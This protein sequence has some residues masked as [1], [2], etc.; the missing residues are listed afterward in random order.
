MTNEE[1]LIDYLKW[2]TADLHKTRQRLR[3]VE[4]AGQEPIAIVGMSCRYPGGVRSPEQ[5]WELVSTGT[6]A[7]DEF[8][9]DRGWNVAE[10]YDPDP[11]REGKS[12]ART[13]GFV[14]DAH[15]FDARFFGIGPREA[16]AIDPQQRLLLEASW[17]ALEHA[18]L[19]PQRLAGSRTGVFVGVMYGDYG[20]RLRFLAP[21]GL[22]G[23]VG[24]GSAGSVASGRIS[25][26]LGLEGPAVTVDTACSSSLVATHL[27]AQALRAGECT[28]ALAGGVTVMATPGVF[29]EFSRQRGL[30]PDGRCKSFGAGADGAGWGEGVGLLVLEKLSDARRN[31]HRVLAVLTGSAVNQDGA[32]N[33]LTAPNGPSQERLIRAALASAGLTPADVDAVEAHGTGT[34]LGDPIEAQALL[35]TYGQ[36]RGGGDPLWLG[37]IKSNIGHTQAAAGVAGII[38]VV[39]ALRHGVLPKTLHAEQPSPHVDWSSGAVGLLTEARPWPERDGGPRRAA[40]SSFGISGTN[41]HLIVEEAPPAP[42]APEGASAEDAPTGG[43]APAVPLPW[44]LSAKTAAALRAQA[45][46][47]AAHLDRHPD[48]DPAAVAYTLA[49]S[50]AQHPHR[51]VVIAEDRA[52]ARQR[53]GFLARG[54]AASNVVTGRAATGGKLAFLFTGQGA[55]HP[56]MGADLYERFPVFAAALDAAC[57]ALDPHLDRPLW[58]VMSGRHGDLLGET[59][60]IQ[61]A[62]FAY[63]TAMHALLAAFGI[64][65]DLL[66]GHSIGELTAAHLAGVLDLADAARLITTRARLMHEMPAGAMLAVTAPL[67][68]V[69]PILAEHPEVDLAAHNSPTSLVLAGEPAALDAVAARLTE[70][71]VRTRRLHVPH[72]FHSVH[73]EPIL[74][75][76]RAVAATVTYHPARLPIVSNLTG[77]V[78]SDAELSDPDYWTRHIRHTVRYTDGTAAL[79][80]LGAT[81]Y[82]ELGP[83][84]TLTTLSQE[85]LR[86]H[87]PEARPPLVPLAA[88]RKP[89][90]RTVLTG[91][92]QLHVA[93]A[94]VDWSPL[95]PHPATVVELPTYPF[96]RVRFWPDEPA[97]GTGAG[98]ARTGEE[99]AFW[100]AV[101]N[102]DAGALASLLGADEEARAALRAVL[103]SLA[104]W[105]RLRCAPP[106][107]GPGP[108]GAADGPDAD[109]PAEALAALRARLAAAPAGEE[110]TV[111]LD[112]LSRE[113]ALVLGYD[114]PEPIDPEGNFLELGFSSFTVLELSNRL[115]ARGLRLAPALF[116][117]HPTPLA[118]ARHLAGLLQDETTGSDRM[119]QPTGS[120]S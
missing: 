61:P 66:I 88:R 94:P 74:D 10:L 87:A 90:V 78:A 17:E 62:L 25:Y 44:L 100:A 68:R 15:H 40:V 104:G 43:S 55:Q 42:E 57:A 30:A 73:T 21:A 6:D 82:V 118:L 4:S 13:G 70:E 117:D 114:D 45:D 58:E 52:D 111:L 14:Y 26:E 65:P 99:A 34:T 75:R 37:S 1:K 12:Y 7:I 49:T 11:A 71:G 72:A 105:H 31:G 24:T 76:F 5:L 33:G 112:L 3:E 103:P 41:A 36:Q 23:Q 84:A 89:A 102:A 19:N 109:G 85:W 39:E 35:A 67:D 20:A 64:R 81:G 115:E 95:H 32:S 91:L 120:S 80:R 8:P 83:D 93:G 47:L 60:Y 9:A 16:L 50:R 96:E 92:A 18:G 63:E 106:P 46:R 28:L 119:P 2:V 48:L 53:L 56:G 22:E 79:H 77:Q 69:A 27:A 108:A 29:V 110:H 98:P 107:P 86:R 59:T 113:A 116:Y 54:E 101:E 38:K 51:A 97:A